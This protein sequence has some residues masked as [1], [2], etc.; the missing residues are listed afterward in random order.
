MNALKRKLGNYDRP[1]LPS[2][3]PSTMPRPTFD[4][5]SDSRWGNSTDMLSSLADVDGQGTSSIC[6]NHQFWINAADYDLQAR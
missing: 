1:H 3:L 4:G 5:K 6:L 2:H